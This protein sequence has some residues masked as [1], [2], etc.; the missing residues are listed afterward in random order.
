[1]QIGF[2]GM[3]VLVACINN[4][5]TMV[6]DDDCFDRLLQVFMVYALPYG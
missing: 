3:A 4:I 1:M 5:L 2:V 6:I